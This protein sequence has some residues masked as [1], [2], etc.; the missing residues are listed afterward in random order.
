MLKISHLFLIALLVVAT[1]Y[2][3]S[4]LSTPRDNH[5]EIEPTGEGWT[6]LFESGDFSAWSLINGN[7]V[8][9]AWSISDGIIHRQ[10]IG[11]DD[12]ITRR[13]Y[14]NFEMRF[15]WKISEGGNSGVKYR[16]RGSLGPEYQIIDE[17]NHRDGRRAS[18]SSASLYDVIAPD[19]NKPLNPPG[20]WNTGRIVA[21]GNHLTHWLNG[22]KVLD[23]DLGSDEWNEALSR[24]KFKGHAD[25][26]TWSG[27]VLLQ[28]HT[29]EVWFK[30]VLIREL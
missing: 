14:D 27:P 22:V 8:S 17:V 23:I 12:I 6:D 21:Q 28:G 1:S 16:T 25:F 11:R 18:R 5:S 10:N 2:A 19:E 20:E 9:S 7:D 30:Q 4:S 26:A 3:S 13:S 15:Y 24:S 29:R